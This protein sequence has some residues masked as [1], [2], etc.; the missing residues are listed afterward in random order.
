MEA[1]APRGGS[2][3]V[4]CVPPERHS[5]DGAVNC[6][7]VASILPWPLRGC[8]CVGVVSLCLKVCPWTRCDRVPGFLVRIFWR[9]G[10]KSLFLWSLFSFSFLGFPVQENQENHHRGEFIVLSLTPESVVLNKLL[11][12]LRCRITFSRAPV[13]YSVGTLV[14][15]P[16]AIEWA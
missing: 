12:R 16:H 6:L 4:F 2:E 8:L 10:G 13:H 1:C 15:S 9:K 3:T 7:W 14:S 5:W 11:R